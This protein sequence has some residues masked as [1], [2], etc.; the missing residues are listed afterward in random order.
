VEKVIIGREGK[1][2]G[3]RGEDATKRAEGL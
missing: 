3:R 1:G 2:W